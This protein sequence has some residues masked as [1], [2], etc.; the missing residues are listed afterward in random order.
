[1]LQGAAVRAAVHR[2]P[3]D[4][5]HPAQRRHLPRLQQGGTRARHLEE[6]RAPENCNSSL[7]FLLV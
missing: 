4:A 5:P 1:M 3:G 7:H 6:P 2:G